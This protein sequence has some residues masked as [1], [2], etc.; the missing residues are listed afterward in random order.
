MSVSVECLCLC[1]SHLLQIINA[2]HRLFM[3]LLMSNFEALNLNILVA[4]QLT[5]LLIVSAYLLN[6]LLFLLDQGLI[7]GSHFL[8][9][10]LQ[11]LYLIIEYLILQ[12]GLRDIPSLGCGVA[13]VCP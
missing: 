3:L 4:S 7:V 2:L 8:I 10:Q 12:L 1:F 11:L 13:H 6:K 5:H 9:P